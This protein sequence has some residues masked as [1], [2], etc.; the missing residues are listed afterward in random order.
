MRGNS[1]GFRKGE[2]FTKKKFDWTG[3]STL[4]NYCV[5]SNHYDWAIKKQKIHR[6]TSK[7]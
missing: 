4:G 5:S 3:T 7:V 2:L 6:K 1:L